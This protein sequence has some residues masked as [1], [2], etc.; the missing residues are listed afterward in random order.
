MSTTVPI[1][2]RDETSTGGFTPE[3]EFLTTRG[4]VRVDSLSVG[5]RVYALSGSTKLAKP[6]FVERIEKASFDGPLIALSGKRLDLRLHPTHQVLFTTKARPQPRYRRAENLTEQEY[7]HFVN[8][9]QTPS[10][11]RVDT[12]DITEFV[13]EFEARATADVHGHTFRA[14]LPDECEPS[15]VNSHTG[16]HFDPTAFKRYQSEIESV[17]DEVS[18]RRG[19]KQRTQ[20]YLFAGDD[21]VELLGWFITEGS[22]YWGEKRTAGIQLAQQTPRHRR[23]IEALL[24]R[25]GI[26][27]SVN[28]RGFRFSSELYGILL[29]SFCGSSSQTK[30]LPAFVWRLATEQQ[31]LLLQ[32]LLRGDGND[33]GVYYTTSNRLAADMLRLCV[34]VGVKPGYTRRGKMWRLFTTSGQRRFRSSLNVSTVDVETSLYRVVVE[35][36]ESVFAGRNGRFQWVGASGVC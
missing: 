1:I 20:P 7:Y 21:F 33:D 4:P 24:D 2:T 26:T 30:R 31:R 19:W 29:E 34:E 14:A 36:Y 8:D 9:W 22:V 5:D 15:Y 23:R 27:P 6:K 25:M 16:Y 28:E 10:G 11:A 32:T 3:T 18:V 35:D 13:D 17:A 12:V